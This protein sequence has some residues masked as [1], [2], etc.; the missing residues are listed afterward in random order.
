MNDELTR[1]RAI[2]N[3]LADFD[4]LKTQATLSENAREQLDAF[5]ERKAAEKVLET[6]IQLTRKESNGGEP[7]DDELVRLRAIRDAVAAFDDH[8]IQADIDWDDSRVCPEYEDYALDEEAVAKE[9]LEEAV[10]LT[11]KEFP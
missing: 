10:Q 2:R 7:F 8:N 9:F 1:L 3:A 4:R 11:R 5:N 6:A